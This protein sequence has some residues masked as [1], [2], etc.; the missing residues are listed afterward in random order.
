MLRWSGSEKMNPR[1]GSPWRKAERLAELVTAERALLVLDGIEAFQSTATPIQGR[2]L[3]LALA[4]LLFELSIRNPGLCVVTSRLPLND[5]GSMANTVAFAN[6][7]RLSNSAGRALLRLS[8]VRGIPELL[9]EQ[10]SRTLNGHA[11]ALRLL[12]AHLATFPQQAKERLEELLELPTIPEGTETSLL[13]KWM[14]EGLG[15]TP[16]CE[17]LSLLGVLDG[18]ADKHVLERLRLEPVEPGLNDFT[19]AMKDREWGQLIGSLRRRSLLLPEDGRSPERVTAHPLIA[20]YFSER[21]R[22][23]APEAWV[24]AHTR[25]S[26]YYEESIHPAPETIDQANPALRAIYHSVRAGDHKHAIDLFWSRVDQGPLHR[27]TEL[28]AP[29]MVMNVLMPF[30]ATDGWSLKPKLDPTDEAYLA[31]S[32]GAMLRALGR[33]E[34]AMTVFTHALEVRKSQED[35]ANASKNASVVSELALATGHLDI[36]RHLAEESLRFARQS[37]NH[38]QI[39]YCLTTY[40]DVLHHAGDLDGALAVFEKAEE[41]HRKVLVPRGFPIAILYRL[42]GIRYC[43]CLLTL[44]RVRDVLQRVSVLTASGPDISGEETAYGMAICAEAMRLDRGSSGILISGERSN[45]IGYADLALDMLRASSSE[46][47]LPKCLLVRARNFSAVNNF[48]AASRDVERALVVAKR[49]QSILVTIDAKIEQARI[50]VTKGNCDFAIKLINDIKSDTCFVNYGR[51][52]NEVQ[53]LEKT[54]D[55]GP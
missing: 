49:N 17:V 38:G 16:M 54:L 11:L 37:G 25:L 18:G 55:L 50:E 22:E 4:T 15:D 1:I 24:V 2:V 27:S 29:G 10:A 52:Q 3:D 7:E 36:A 13:L 51:A 34:G 39:I 5:L 28:N 48:E 31:N 43:D 45:A 9:L 42:P 32:T 8:G 19:H 14:V 47:Y 12:A 26:E 6:L 46:L 44:G 41:I 30:Y 23:A 53:E 20:S 40:G 35:W 21:L 33:L